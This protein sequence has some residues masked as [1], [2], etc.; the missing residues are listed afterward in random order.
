MTK[1]ILHGGFERQNNEP[2]NSF[3]RELVRDLPTGATL[4]LVYFASEY[5]EVREAFTEQT[6]RVHEITG[7][8]LRF[9]LATEED[10]MSQVRQ[11]D[12]VH[13]RGGNTTKLLSIL[14][15]Y[16]ELV[17]VL[18]EKKVISGSSAGAYALAK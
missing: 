12:G 17:T 5:E 18:K 4:L 13:F 1:Y 10:F 15:G 8:D 2:N 14:R 16:P 6:N 3:Y 7:K 9:V 11:A